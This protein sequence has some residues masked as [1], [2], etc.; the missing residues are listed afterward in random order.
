MMLP[1]LVFKAAVSVQWPQATPWW[2]TSSWKH[3]FGGAGA[4]IIC[5]V[6]LSCAGV[7]CRC[8]VQVPC[9]GVKFTCTC[10]LHMS[11]AAV[12]CHVHV[13]CVM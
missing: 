13:S 4:D 8:H 12:M 3:P 2:R 9:A 10:H 5:H 6:K 1:Y 7:M 11:C